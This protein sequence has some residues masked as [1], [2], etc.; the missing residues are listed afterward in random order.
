MEKSFITLGP[1]QETKDLNLTA[2]ELCPRHETPILLVDTP[3]A[4]TL[5]QHD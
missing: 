4:V 3:E 2:V 5:S 1:I